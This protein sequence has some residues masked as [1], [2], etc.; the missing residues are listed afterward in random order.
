MYIILKIDWAARQVTWV[1]RQ[2]GYGMNCDVREATERLDVG[3]ARE[4]LDV[5]EATEG[6]AE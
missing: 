5:G 4:R 2:N 6:V 1:K 3:G